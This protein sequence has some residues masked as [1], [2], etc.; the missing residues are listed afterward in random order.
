MTVNSLNECPNQTYGLKQVRVYFALITFFLLFASSCIPHKKILYLQQQADEVDTILF[1]RPD[2]R[3]KSGD[4]LYIQV[5][6]LDEKSYAMFN[7][8]RS[9]QRTT[10]QGGGGIG[11]PQMFLYGYNI[12][13]EGNV[14][15]PVVGKVNVSGK[16]LDEANKYIEELVGEFLI[17]ATV[18][19]KLVNF[20]VTV[21][22]EVG[23]PGKYYIYDNRINILDLIS[24]SGDLTAFGNRNITIVRQTDEGATFGK[25]NLNDA[26]AMRSDYFYLQPNDIVYV[27]PYK[28]ER[29]GI[30]QFP[31]SL[32]FS[33]VSFVLFLV[34]YFSN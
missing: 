27:E 17:G 28:L 1:S 15:M 14:T 16:T 6:T 32:V 30:S 9:G 8:D 11:N 5:L 29:L 13:D 21:I 34:T 24:V 10:T 20:S 4:I 33:T 18:L 7:S 25:I 22:G 3:L 26:D 23:S 2:Y 19:V 12:D 31:I